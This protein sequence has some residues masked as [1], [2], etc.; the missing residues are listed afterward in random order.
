MHRSFSQRNY[1]SYQPPQPQQLPGNYKV[2]SG[3]PEKNDNSFLGRPQPQQPE[4]QPQPKPKR[5]QTE[6][7]KETTVKMRQK[8]MEKREQN[9]LERERLLEIERKYLEEKV[10]KKA[11]S[12]KKK[13]IKNFSCAN[14]NFHARLH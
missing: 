5:K 4:S 9:R 7:Q 1:Q 10:I 14:M 3:A 2:N 6:A 11:I 8:L 12:I 13:Q